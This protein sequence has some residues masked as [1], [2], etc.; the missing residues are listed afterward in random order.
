M[1]SMV[2]PL[3]ATSNATTFVG[4]ITVR[5]AEPFTVNPPD[6]CFADSE[7][8]WFEES[9][10]PKLEAV[11]A[12]RGGRTKARSQLLR[13]LSAQHF[14]CCPSKRE[15]HGQSELGRSCTFSGGVVRIE[16][17]AATAVR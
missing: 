1:Y 5:R 8:E 4:A 10:L 3:P 2:R 17:S 9:R 6:N 12:G 7:L 14:P 13:A 15:V 11:L 16:D